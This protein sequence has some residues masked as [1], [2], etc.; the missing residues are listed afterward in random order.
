MID[1]RHAPARS[2]VHRT[3]LVLLLAYAALDFVT[4]VIVERL[5]PIGWLLALAFVGAVAGQIG[6]LAA[7]AALGPFALAVRWPLVLLA[8]AGLYLCFCFGLVVAGERAGFLEAIR[9]VGRMSLFIPVFFLCAQVPLGIVKTL[10]G[11]RILPAGET[12]RYSAS[13]A[14]QF[15][16]LHLFGLTAAV[17]VSMALA[18][19]AMDD[20]AQ[21]LDGELSDVEAQR[22]AAVIWGGLLLWCGFVC[23]YSAVWT[24][25]AVWACFLARHPS[26]GLRVMVGLWLGLSIAVIVFVA[27]V[28]AEL[29][30]SIRGEIVPATFLHF[31]AAAAVLAGSL[32]LLRRGGCTMI[33]ADRKSKSIASDPAGGATDK[34]KDGRMEGWK[35]GRMEGW[36]DGRMEGWKDGR[37]EGWAPCVPNPNTPPLHRSTTPP[38]H[39]STAPPLHRSTTPPLHHSTAPPLHRST[40]PPLHRSTTPPLHRSNT[41]PHARTARKSHSVRLAGPT[42]PVSGRRA[43]LCAGPDR[44]PRWKP[45]ARGRRTVF[46]R[47]PRLPIAFATRTWYDTHNSCEKRSGAR[48]FRS[49]LVLVTRLFV[50]RRVVLKMPPSN[51]G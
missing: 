48:P 14:R 3:I 21:R 39:H 30:G 49:A 17:A 19:V 29:G 10:R 23:A 13:E 8:T 16:L 12:V 18:K 15:G 25:T 41:P 43:R 44:P 32:H 9:E 35:D 5:E 6:F 47:K 20:W 50:R 26:H 33:R 45:A 7:W 22:M 1:P 31:A 27:A 36:K 28:R 2:A 37:M 4:P 42:R 46:F 40:T 11:W 51:R 34:G 38:L 24:P